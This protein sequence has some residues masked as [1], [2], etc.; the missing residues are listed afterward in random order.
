M[1]KVRYGQDDLD[2]F[3]REAV[4]DILVVALAKAI[5]NV[6]A[7]AVSIADFVIKN[8]AFLAFI[9][10][11]RQNPLTD[12]TPIRWI[13]IDVFRSDRHVASVMDE[14]QQVIR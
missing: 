12:F 3:G 2:A 7:G 10:G 9:V 6:P 8:A 13:S 14:V 5:D 1:V 4:A 11:A